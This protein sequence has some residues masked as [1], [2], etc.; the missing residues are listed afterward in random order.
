MHRTYARIPA[1][2]Y[3][4][5][6]HT[7]TDNMTMALVPDQEHANLIARI[8]IENYGLRQGERIVVAPTVI[9]PIDGEQISHIEVA[10]TGHD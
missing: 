1:S 10:L 5:S 7:D 6:L 9:R 4:I 3:R 2:F 8:L